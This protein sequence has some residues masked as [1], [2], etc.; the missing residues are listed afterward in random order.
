MKILR[1]ATAA[2]GGTYIKNPTWTKAFDYDLVT[3]H[4]LGGCIMADD[5]ASGVTDHKGQVFKGKTGKTVHPGLYVMD[6]AIYPGGR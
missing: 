1:K 6:G 4:P 3:V 2:L 5:A